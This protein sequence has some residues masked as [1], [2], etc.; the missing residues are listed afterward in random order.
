M[1]L[2]RV[3]E[4]LAG[5][6][7]AAFAV[8]RAG[9]PLVMQCSGKADLEWQRP[10]NRTTVFR[11]ASLTKPMTALLIMLL[12]RDGVL[13]LDTSIRR[14]L[15]DYPAHADRVTLRH[16]LTHTSGIPDFARRPAFEAWSRLDHTDAE[17]RARFADQPLHFEPGTRCSYSNSGYRLLDMIASTVTGTPFATLMTERVFA[18]AGMSDTRLLSDDE[19][20]PGRARG[21]RRAGDTFVNAPYLSATILGG[22][23]G[24]GS[25]LAD[26]LRF[27]QVVRAGTLIDSATLTV[28][29]TL[30]SGRHEGYGFGWV[31]ST[32]RDHA[33][34]HHNGGIGGFA[35]TYVRV[36]DQDL[37]I[38][39]LTN[40]EGFQ[41]DDVA[42]VVLDEAL[43]VPAPR[44]PVGPPSVDRSGTYTDPVSEFR[45]TTGP[46][47]IVVTRGD[48]S[49]RMVAI[50][51]T[52]YVDSTDEG[53]RLHCHD[54]ESA[55]TL[56]YPLWW[57]TGY[58]DATM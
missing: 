10:V 38:V 37:G 52:T 58:R 35:S 32:Y 31:L 36:P 42:R 13:D 39:V 18:P 2:S 49:H 24:I 46:D 26:L 4:L 8:T 44:Q 50:D 28:P 30:A 27:D 7:G 51:S 29:L 47:H 48:R 14:Y 5:V 6:P 1:D 54:A 25:T 41:C 57:G 34:I 53:V 23:G 17:L 20:V 15:P 33:V 56:V 19:I 55:G 43:P 45:I 22:A 16:L 9:K 11:L 3:D 12:V 21:Y 40:L